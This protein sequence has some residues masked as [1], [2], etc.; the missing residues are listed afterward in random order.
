M[1]SNV[2]VGPNNSGKSTIIGAVR[3]LE[4]GIKIARVRAPTRVFVGETACVGHRAPEANLP[5][6]LENV[7]TNYNAE[8]SKVSFRLSNGNLLELIFPSDGGCILVPIARDLVV[9]TPGTFRTVSYSLTIVPVLRPVDY[10]ERRRDEHT[11]TRGLSTH[12]AS[13]HFRS[14]WRHF[15]ENFDTFAALISTTWNDMEIFVRNIMPRAAN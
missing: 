11:V 6:S 15:G 4:S 14:Y 8:D 7:H 12:R 3:A 5:I 10:R 2:P 13:R 9:M 1:R